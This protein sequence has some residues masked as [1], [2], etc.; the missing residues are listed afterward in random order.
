[1]ANYFDTTTRWVES[2]LGYTDKPLLKNQR[3]IAEPDRIF[4][5]GSH[6]EIARLIRDRRNPSHWMLNGD[7]FSNTTSKHQAEVLSAITR[8]GGSFA[9][10]TIPYSALQA[11]DVLLDTVQIIESTSDRWEDKQ[12]YFFEMPD[13]AT[14]QYD[15]E[16]ADLGGWQNSKTGEFVAR[17]KMWG[18]AGPKRETCVV[19]ADPVGYTHFMK[20]YPDD[21]DRA[22][23]ECQEFTQAIEAHRRFS[24][25]EWEEIGH[26][27]RETGRRRLI[28]RRGWSEWDLVDMPDSPTG[29]AYVR[30]W[31]R[32]WLGESVI[33][34]K[35][36]YRGWRKCRDCEGTGV[37]EPYSEQF[38]DDEG[39]G[40]LTERQDYYAPSTE[41]YVTIVE[42]DMVYRHRTVAAT[43]M[44]TQCATCGG[45]RRNRVNRQRWAYFLSGFDSNEAR[46]SY[47][48]CELPPKARP[49]SVAEAYQVLK[50]RA[51]H[52]AEQVG[53][54]VE[55]QGDI[56]WIPMPDLTLRDLRKQGTYLKRTT[57]TEE[58]GPDWNRTRVTHFTGG[59]PYVL[60]TNHTVSEQVRVGRLTYA[61]GIMRHEPDR[62]R[63]DHARI[64]LGDGKTWGLVVKNT[65][66]I[67][68]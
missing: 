19:C 23:T 7:R 2:C 46:P 20:R 61:R 5:Y 44:T 10:V 37:V 16:T 51:V 3:L 48:F 49:T 32:H 41:Q 31:R 15:T 42:D 25:G 8:R 45:A 58:F 62:R 43:R 28:S 40:P 68:A 22:W 9:R 53:R 63:P 59:E 65:V 6:F 17:L 35:V 67:G 38:A 12:E 29:V 36:S 14:W 30:S 60:S 1:M 18:E 11:A 27:V 55:R 66:P 54:E 56:F 26:H 64:K 39:Y 4:S 47:F 21:R 52:L 50:P 57:E 24:H 33:K 13:S 34:A